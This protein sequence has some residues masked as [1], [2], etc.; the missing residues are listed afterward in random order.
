MDRIRLAL[1]DHDG[2]SAGMARAAKAADLLRRHLDAIRPTLLDEAT[3]EPHDW[4]D[5]D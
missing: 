5:F 2:I 1:G 4:R 3:W